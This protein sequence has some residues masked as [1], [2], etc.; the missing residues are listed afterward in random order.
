M[1]GFLKPTPAKVR[2]TELRDTEL[3]LIHTARQAEYFTAM[4]RVLREQA[5][6]LKNE[7]AADKREADA[8]A[9]AAAEARALRIPPAPPRP[10]DMARPGAIPSMPD[11]VFHRAR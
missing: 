8:E 7:V 6:R 2:K 5:A 4:T 9:Q 1:F 3:Q 10:A 11:E